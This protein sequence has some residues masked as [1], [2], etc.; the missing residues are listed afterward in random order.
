MPSAATTAHQLKIQIDGIRPPVWRRVLVPSGITLAR[1]HQVIQQ[2]FGWWD[3]HLH[4]FEIGC[5]R[6]RHRRR[7]RMG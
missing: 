3:Y 5:V 7:R 6:L 2:V 1:L 4:E